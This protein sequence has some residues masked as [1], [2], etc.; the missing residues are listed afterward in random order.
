MGNTN[1]WRIA[2][3]VSLCALSSSEV[4]AMGRTQAD[5]DKIC[6]TA[7]QLESDAQMVQEILDRDYAKVWQ[8][9]ENRDHN[10]ASY[11]LD[12]GRLK[13]HA[14]KLA[15]LDLLKIMD[16]DRDFFCEEDE[17]YAEAQRKSRRNDSESEEDLSIEDQSR[18]PRTA[19][20]RFV[21]VKNAL[22]GSEEDFGY[23][24]RRIMSIGERIR[25]ACN[26]QDK[27]GALDLYGAP[28][29]R[30]QS[31][32]VKKQAERIRERLNFTMPR[33]GDLT[34]RACQTS[35]APLRVKW[36]QELWDANHRTPK[37]SEGNYANL[38]LVKESTSRSKALPAEH[39]PE[40]D[41]PARDEPAAGSANA[42]SAS[43]ST[44]RVQIVSSVQSGP[45]DTTPP[46]PPVAPAPIP[47]PI[48][49][50]PTPVPPAPALPA[51]QPV[52]PSCGPPGQICGG[53]PAE[54]PKLP[55]CE[56][57]AFAGLHECR[58]PGT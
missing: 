43:S 24:E 26:A 20:E 48:Q 57:A 45:P 3:T 42:A 54:K 36:D 30:T 35:S 29:D 2:F 46:G 37:P 11:Q 17:H 10:R 1:L 6:Q 15:N 44:P 5:R 12:C 25:L 13:K 18:P 7:K 19:C 28:H 47:V 14:K 8:A 58:I 49:P 41:A 38:T 23:R 52:A 40:P 55:I 51:P 31:P 16:E 27:G 39:L 53:A 56:S 34:V 50:G 9:A 21:I 33:I 4:Y 22:F 32:I